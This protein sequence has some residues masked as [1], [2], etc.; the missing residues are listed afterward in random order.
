MKM[1]PNNQRSQTSSSERVLDYGGLDEMIGIALLRAYNTA[2]KFFYESIEKEFRPGFYTTL[3]LIQKNPGLTQKALAH[4]IGRDPSTIVPI[5]DQ[6]EDKG[7][8]V[9]RRSEVDRRA[10][11]LHATPTG[12]AMARRLD[13]KVTSVEAKIEESFGRAN[14]RQL[15]NLLKSFQHS[16]ED[17]AN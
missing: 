13:K 6:L 11:A 17:D 16:F 2:Y 5:L 15:L 10:H 8:V 14:N 1:K 3:S 7:W 9:R 4:A 12:A